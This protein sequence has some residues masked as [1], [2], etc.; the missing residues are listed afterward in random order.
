MCALAA[1]ALVITAC[2][3]DSGGGDSGATDIPI[4]ADD[5]SAVAVESVAPADVPGDTDVPSRDALDQAADDATEAVD[6][7]EAVQESV[8]G[9]SATFSANG[10]TW[11]FSSV[12]CAF[13][14]DQIGQPGA[15]FNLS[16]IADGLQLYASIDDSG[17]SHS[18]SLNDIEDFENPSVSLTIDPFVAGAAGAPSE[19]LTLDDKQVSAEVTMIDGNT[20]QPTAE[21]ATFSAT[22]P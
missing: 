9:G 18:L 8:G 6:D 7:L 1:G 3:G 20:N 21:P 14:E 16:A 5:P 19:F 17:A 11:E 4:D 13:G 12:L 22:C 2:G 15:V 10:Q